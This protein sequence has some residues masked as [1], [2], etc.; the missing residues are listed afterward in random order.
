MEGCSR[1]SAAENA[2]DL[3]M[4]IKT[5]EIDE[6]A[7]GEYYSLIDGF[8]RTPGEARQTAS[9]CLFLKRVGLSDLAQEVVDLSGSALTDS[10]LQDEVAKSI[11]T[12]VAGRDDESAGSPTSLRQSTLDQVTQGM[13]PTVNDSDGELVIKTE[14]Q[15]E[16]VD[17]GIPGY[18]SKQIRLRSTGKEQREYDNCTLVL[19]AIL[20][21]QAQDEDCDDVII[22]AELPLLL[23]V[24]TS[25]LLLSRSLAWLDGP[26]EIMKREKEEFQQY[27]SSEETR[28]KMGL[29]WFATRTKYEGEP[30]V[31]DRLTHNDDFM[32]RVTYGSPKLRYL[33]HLVDKHCLLADTSKEQRPIT[34]F[35][36]HP[37]TQK[38]LVM[39][40]RELWF[41]V[42][43][44]HA[45]MTERERDDVV[46]QF[47]AG[48]L[49]DLLICEYSSVGDGVDLQRKCNV[50]VQF[51]SARSGAAELQ[52]LG[53]VRRPGQIF[54]QHIYRLF[55]E[56]TF[57]E[58]TDARQKDM[59]ADAVMSWSGDH[60]TAVQNHFREN[61]ARG[62]DGDALF[63]QTASSMTDLFTGRD[64]K[65][66]APPG[67]PL[68]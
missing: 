2:S 48:G 8:R 32:E 23:L 33:C 45:H 12:E 49:I 58:W 31:P 30:V 37:A 51:E 14:E 46:A 43:A 59:S 16:T 25:S 61:L 67:Q 63:R 27:L 44:I 36:E 42:R 7:M 9:T 18:E 3:Q 19:L 53:C 55:V 6:D 41:N 66:A 40:F 57:D 28:Q 4:V 17:G 60:L 54:V 56:A 13:S 38:F 62:A 20:F 52:A 21:D 26:K 15:T 68:T 50:V 47:N 10:Q 39:F 65:R 24:L 5:E 11:P 64:G 22:D 34:V 1:G 29:T 35:V